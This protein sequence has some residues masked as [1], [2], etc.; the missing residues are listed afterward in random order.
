VGSPNTWRYP[1]LR[2]VI[3]ECLDLGLGCFGFLDSD[4]IVASRYEHFEV[5]IE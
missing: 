5:L 3:D 4:D 1:S 2:A